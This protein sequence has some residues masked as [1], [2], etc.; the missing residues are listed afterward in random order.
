[1]SDI[2]LYEA[3]RTTRAVR[4]LRPAPIPDDVLRRVLEAATFAPS[5]GN[6]QAW[7]IIVVRDPAL[8]QALAERQRKYWSTYATAGR[9]GAAALPEAARDKALRALSAG[10]YLAEHFHELPAVLVVCFDPRGVMV[11]DAGLGRT[12][13]VGGA[14]IYPAVQNLLLACR[15]EGLGCVLT[16][17]LCAAEPE[18]R[19]LLALPEPWGTAAYVPIGYPVGTGHG[20]LSRKPVEEMVFGDRFG[21]RFF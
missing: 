18:L 7:R 12:A 9:A 20:P 15:A 16:T 2:P 17:L 10:D 21:E 14:S 11:T 3:M 6:R 1:M 5:G 8:K 19:P 4:R 13:V